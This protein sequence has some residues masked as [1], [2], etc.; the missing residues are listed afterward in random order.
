[1]GLIRRA[2]PAESGSYWGGPEAGG[3]WGWKDPRSTFT[4]PV[5]LDVFP[6]A[7][8]IHLVRHGVDVAWSL[9]KR[10]RKR[11]HKSERKTFS[12]RCLDLAGGLELW[13]EYVTEGL[14]RMAELPP[15]RGLMLRFEDL[16]AEP[17]R[18]AGR[19]SEFLGHPIRPE[20]I[21]IRAET[22]L[23]YRRDA[24]A[25]AFAETHRHPL[26]RQLEYEQ[27]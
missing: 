26:L 24:E 4:L 5:W 11:E 7:K 14:R 21:A 18:S 22:A 27:P 17:D 3:P 20:V 19:L 16:V 23:A 10:E 12:E 25:R 6:Q 1:L 8:V 2:W 15:G 13:A 9:R